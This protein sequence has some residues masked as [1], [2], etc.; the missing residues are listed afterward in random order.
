MHRT[1]SAI[2]LVLLASCGSGPEP[3]LK[4]GDPYERYLGALE[5]ADSGDPES[6]KSVEALLKDSD[7]LARTGAIVALAQAKP[8]GALKLLTGMLSDGDPGVRTEAVRAVAGF[9]DPS[10]VEPIARMLKDAMEEPRR[11]AAIAL[12]E[13]GDQPPVRAALLEAFE[14]KSAGVAFNAYQSLVRVTGRADL[15]RG[16]AAAKQALQ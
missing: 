6:M 7:P 13:F 9:K 1:L 11:V 4:S 16:A 3:N 5:A 2:S 8:A 10:S 15:P 12:G 14:D